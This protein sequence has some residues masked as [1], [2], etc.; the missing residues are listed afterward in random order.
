MG[1]VAEM[2]GFEPGELE[3]I[4]GGVNHFNWLVD[5]RRKGSGESYFDTFKEQVRENKWW[6]KVYPNVPEQVFTR[7]VLETFD[8]YPIGYDS[9]IAEYLPFFYSPDERQR[10]G[11]PD[12]AEH[13][14]EFIAKREALAAASDEEKQKAESM[15]RSEFHNVPFP[16]DGDHPYYREQP[17]EIMEAFATNNPLYMTAIVIPNHGNIDNLPD[18]AIVDIPAV[19]VGGQVRGIHVGALP[20]FG[21]ELCR[22]QITVHELLVE[23]TAE[24]SRR[25]LY[26]S[27]ALDP[28]VRS[29][30]QARDIADAFLEEYREDLPQFRS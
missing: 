28:Y 17:T 11:Y 18:D 25:K 7:D 22:R 26:Q 19:A 9:H 3:V 16:R 10:L 14:R 30:R 4:S 5:I 1:V 27:M 21:A 23:A 29:I 8:C 13:L 15:A 12:H 20:A 6:Q 24:G 2:L